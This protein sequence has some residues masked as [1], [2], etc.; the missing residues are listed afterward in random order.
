M[1]NK[2]KGINKQYFFF[3]LINKSFFKFK[4]KKKLP[5]YKQVTKNKETFLQILCKILFFSDLS[6]FRE[7]KPTMAGE[8]K[9]VKIDVGEEMDER[10]KRVKNLYEIL[11]K[12]NVD[13]YIRIE[14]EI[15]FDKIDMGELF[16]ESLN[17]ENESLFFKELLSLLIKEY[18]VSCILHH[19]ISNDI[20]SKYGL[21]AL[22]KLL[23]NCNYFIPKSVIRAK[24]IG[25]GTDERVVYFWS[26]LAYK[27]NLME[28]F[29]RIDPVQSLH[30]SL[31]ISS[32]L[33][34]L[35]SASCTYLNERSENDRDDPYKQRFKIWEERGFDIITRCYEQNENLTK[36]F[37]LGEKMKDSVLMLLR[38]TQ[39]FK[40]ISSE[41]CQNLL[42]EM[43]T[44]P[45]DEDKSEDYKIILT[46][47]FPIMGFFLIDFWEFSEN[48]KIYINNFNRTSK[49]CCQP[50]NLLKYPLKIIKNTFTFLNA[51]ITKFWIHQVNITRNLYKF[52]SFY[53][54]I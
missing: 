41:P 10:R 34:A 22:E 49:K 27:P 1:T 46:I 25:N 9:P 3:I 15:K 35:T 17:L 7:D 50:N 19:Q 13:E 38:Q 39:S 21:R 44:Y 52:Y 29:W 4:K 48:S 32:I 42:Q 24:F 33:D 28:Y 31:I 6:V 47:V 23:N 54:Y 18:G 8:R 20:I 16:L 12:D 30:S 5:Q 51:P 45:L 53:L 37:L 14:K 43:W 2:K 36:G 26:V 11:C 40:V